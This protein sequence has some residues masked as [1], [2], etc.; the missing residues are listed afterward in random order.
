LLEFRLFGR[1][2]KIRKRTDP[3]GTHSHR[4]AL[5]GTFFREIAANIPSGAHNEAFAGIYHGGGLLIL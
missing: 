3:P 1:F 4:I 2:C 5:N